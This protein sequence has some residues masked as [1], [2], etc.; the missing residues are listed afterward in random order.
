MLSRD[1]NQVDKVTIGL[2]SI[3]LPDGSFSRVIFQQKNNIRRMQEGFAAAAKAYSKQPPEVVLSVLLI[4]NW[5]RLKNS[6]EDKQYLDLKRRFFQALFA[7]FKDVNVVI[8]DFSSHEGLMAEEKSMMHRQQSVANNLDIVKIRAV[9]D[10]QHFRHLQLDSNTKIY[11]FKQLY[12][13]TFGASVS[14]QKDS[15]MA[16]CYSKFGY[17]SAQNKIVYTTPTGKLAK[18]L[19]EKSSQYYKENKDSQKFKRS[20]VCTIYQ[21]IFGP[22]LC[23]IGFAHKVI[24]QGTAMFPANMSL[25]NY[26]ITYSLMGAINMSWNSNCKISADDKELSD[27]PAIK[28]GDAYCDFQSFLYVI[29]KLTKNFS[30]HNKVWPGLIDAKKQLLGI[31]NLKL[32]LQMLVEFYNHILNKYSDYITKLAVVIPCSP[33]GDRI[34][35]DLF[36]CKAQVLHEKAKQSAY[37]PAHMKF[38]KK[39]LPYPYYLI[40][41]GLNEKKATGPR[42]AAV[43]GKISKVESPQVAVRMARSVMFWAKSKKRNLNL[44]PVKALCLLTRK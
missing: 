6:Y 7:E 15:L 17:V 39:L 23:D 33:Q 16:C 12:R 31:S 13:Q 1:E 14:Q 42:I 36:G 24:I 21:G 43:L 8:Q 41:Y 20:N 28:I 40:K 44:E 29:K 3:E 38:S 19:E 9:I 32:E 34:T 10:N 11:D 27:L 35:L 25:P 37:F 5:G 2:Y 30:F 4:P 22:A 26:R 18:A